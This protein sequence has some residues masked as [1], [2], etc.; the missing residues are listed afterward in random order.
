MADSYAIHIARATANSNL[1]RSF[2]IPVP[3]P[4]ISLGRHTCRSSRTAN[5][6]DRIRVGQE[7]ENADPVISG[8]NHI[9]ATSVYQTHSSEFSNC[10]RTA[11]LEYQSGKAGMMKKGGESG[12]EGRGSRL[13]GRI[14]QRNRNCFTT[15]REM[16]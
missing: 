15:R 9:V 1:N 8:Q 6:N 2:P 5:R 4:S 14:E 11:I 3:I 16:D 12:V 13:R 7:R 10:A